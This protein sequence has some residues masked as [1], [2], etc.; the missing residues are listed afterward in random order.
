MISP[1]NSSAVLRCLNRRHFTSIRIPHSY[2]FARVLL[3]EQ[4]RKGI[5]KKMTS[6][7]GTSS[8]STITYIGTTIRVC[9]LFLFPSL[10]YQNHDSRSNSRSSSHLSSPK[11]VFSPPSIFFEETVIGGNL[12]DPLFKN[13]F[14]CTVNPF[15]LLLLCP[16]A[17][18]AGSH[19]GAEERRGRGDEMGEKINFQAASLLAPIAAGVRIEKVESGTR[20]C[21]E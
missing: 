21:G 5:T 19:G 15:R 2:S 1:S 11:I 6:R 9:A 13:H 20:S 18:K 8:P 12:D 16:R 4:S 7:A 10:D 14:G 3:A 17:K